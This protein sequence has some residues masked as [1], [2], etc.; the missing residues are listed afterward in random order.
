MGVFSTKTV[1]RTGSMRGY[2]PDDFFPVAHVHIVIHHDDEF[3]VHKLAKERPAAH[4]HAL[5][6]S[7]V[8]FFHADHRHAVGTAFGRQ[9]EIGDFGELFLQERYEHHSTPRPKR[10]WFIGRFARV[11]GVV[12]RLSRMVMRSTVNT[13]KWSCSLQ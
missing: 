13:G 10:W 6:V 11:G 8:L 1:S 9:V 2:R 7:G 5:G 4:H 12:N 3:G